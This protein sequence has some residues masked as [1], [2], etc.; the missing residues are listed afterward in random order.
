MK[1]KYVMSP[2]YILTLENEELRDRV[3]ELTKQFNELKK[4]Y[5][6]E[7]AE[8]V[9]QNKGIHEIVQERQIN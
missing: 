5:E 3:M 4:K 1:N 2:N 9:V 8:G 7:F 6:N